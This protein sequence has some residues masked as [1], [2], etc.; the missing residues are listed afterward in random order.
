MPIITLLTDFGITDPYVAVM[1]GVILSIAPSTTLVDISHHV[2]PQDVRTAAG[3][4]ESAFPWFPEGTV[5]IAVVDPGVGSD[6]DILAA[7]VEGQF[8]VA[9]DNGLIHG[10]LSRGGPVEIRRL[11]NRSLFRQPVSRTFHGRDIMA[12]VGAHLSAG[13]ALDTVGGRIPMDALARL[14]TAAPVIDEGGIRGRVTR[15][16]HFGNLV[17]D[18]PS[19]MLPL[20]MEN[21]DHHPQT[22]I[23]GRTI[24]GIQPSYASVGVDRPL[25]VIG[26]DDTLEIAVNGGSAQAMLAAAVGDTVTVRWKPA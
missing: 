24:R 12:P 15:I 22:L 2:P 23:N 19:D 1:K 16:D 14:E 4:L 5:H 13:N 6:R 3:I 21:F 9:P 10:V 7:T 26:S 18:I 11:E 25:V 17:T 20:D 8:L